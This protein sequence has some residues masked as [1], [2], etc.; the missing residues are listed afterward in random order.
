M[1]RS[2]SDH[3]PP[4]GRPAPPSRR[5]AAKAQTRGRLLDAARSLFMERGYEAATIRDIVA[6]AGLSTGA[7]FAS[8]SDKSELF[9][10]VLEEDLHKQLRITEAAVALDAPVK[11]GLMELLGKAYEFQLSQLP[12]L[13]AATGLSW[14]H[15]L[16]GP[17]GNRPVYGPAVDAM[18]TIL[19]RGVAAGE[20][21]DGIDEALIAETIW[22]AYVTNYRRAMFDG[23][24]LKALTDRLGAQIDLVLAS[25]RT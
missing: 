17:M 6:R 8:F 22:A 19:S 24:D 7:V 20:L 15:G 9:N 12:L 5:A 23:W 1:T 10:A 4:R 2:V 21:A 25:A 16:S 14:T 18:K 3:R 11:D 13:Q